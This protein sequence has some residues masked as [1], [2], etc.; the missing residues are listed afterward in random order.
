MK[1]IP[2][3]DGKDFKTRTIIKQV[4]ELSPSKVINLDEMRK[5]IK[6]L[7][8]L[9]AAEGFLVLEDAE[10]QLLSV[11]VREFPWNVA[12]RELLRI[13]DDVC[14]AKAV[15]AKPDLKAVTG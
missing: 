4:C 12:N 6:I 1:S 8:T 3:R 10:H 15:E 9:D 13:I 11:A 5:R 14:E 2:L 7:D